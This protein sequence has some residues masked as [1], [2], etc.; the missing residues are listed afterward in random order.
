MPRSKKT[1][2]ETETPDITVDTTTEID[3]GRLLAAVAEFAYSVPHEKFIYRLGS[4]WK[5]ETPVTE[6]GIRQFLLA[7]QY[8]YDLVELIVKKG[9]FHRTLAT[10]VVPGQPPIARDEHDHPV[11]NLYAHPSLTPADH[12]IPHPRIE[13]ILRWLCACPD[14]TDPKAIEGLTWF[15]HWVARKV[16]NPGL[17]P[18]VAPIFGTEPGA[19][20]GTLYRIIAAMLGEGNCAIVERQ[21]LESRFTPWANKLFVLGDEV[22]S[23]DN[24]TDVSERLKIMIA[25][26]ETTIEL[27]NVNAYPIP[28]RKAFIF[29]SN[30]RLSPLK[31]SPND[32][33]YTYFRNHKPV[34]PEYETLLKSCYA[35]DGETFTED[36]VEEIRGFWRSLLDT[37]VDLGFVTRPF[38]NQAREELIQ[39]NEPGHALFVKALLEDGIDA[40]IDQLLDTPKGLK[41]RGEAQRKEWDFGAQGLSKAVVYEAYRAFCDAE[42]KHALSA[43]RFGPALRT[44]DGVEEGRNVT[45]SGRKVRYWILP[46]TTTHSTDAWSD[47]A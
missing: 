31:V 2:T 43:A 5:P 21:H 35:P 1:E 3:H 4:K 26:P 36:F 27:K 33:R 40:L 24:Q 45:P 42:G 28:N 37:P 8:P 9:L 6:K 25:S 20:K 17:L 13:A 14:D 10:D 29:A 11:L 19:G 44:L 30:D 18:M 23:N 34:T 41:F 7:R 22:V 12:L 32:R 39:V 47:V 15:F 38:T 46:R 16:Q